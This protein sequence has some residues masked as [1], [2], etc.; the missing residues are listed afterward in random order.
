MITFNEEDRIADAL[1]S[2][3]GIVDEILIIDSQSTDRTREIAAASGAR[4]VIRPFS[5]YA[6]Q[7]NFAREQSSCEWILNLDADERLSPKLRQAIMDL[8]SEPSLPVGGFR[9]RRKAWYLGRW[10]SHSGWYPDCKLRLF[11]R[12]LSHWQGKVHERLILE[13]RAGKLDGEILHFTYR[14]IADHV[15]RINRYTTMQAE[16]IAMKKRFLLLRALL[17][18]PVTFFR[19][20]IFKMGF[21]DRF[22]GLVIA[23]VSSWGTAMKYLKARSIRRRRP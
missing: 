7:K 5:D 12:D 22:P 18:P 14:N 19:F 21:L 4:V 23:L 8:K 13:G 15:S 20:Y 10:I 2:V 3:R 6:D 11:R 17:L 9:I 16:E 1:D